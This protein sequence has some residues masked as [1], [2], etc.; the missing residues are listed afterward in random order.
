MEHSPK[1]DDLKGIVENEAANKGVIFFSGVFG[2]SAAALILFQLVSIVIFLLDDS[3]RLTACPRSFDLDTPVT[4]SPIRNAEFSQKDA[5]MRGFIRRYLLSKF[6]RAKDD[7][8]PFL[9]FMISHTSGSLRR[10]YKDF[11]SNKSEYET[12]IL[13]GVIDKFYPTSSTDVKISAS[14]TPGVWDV[15]IGGYMVS[16]KSNTEDRKAV[17][18]NIVVESG[19]STSSNPEGLYVSS[20]DDGI[21][22]LDPISGKTGKRFSGA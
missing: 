18:I 13:N 4:L 12:L 5:W 6:P 1:N 9:Q 20:D 21:E 14:K 11:Y 2:L 10:K 15:A 22:L 8:T 3:I 17:T 7:V 19:A 16:R